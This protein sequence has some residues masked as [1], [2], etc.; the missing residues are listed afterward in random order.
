[1]RVF[2]RD[3]T[4][5]FRHIHVVM[6]VAILV[7]GLSLWFLPTDKPADETSEISSTLSQVGQTFFVFGFSAIAVHWAF[8]EFQWSVV[9]LSGESIEFR[10]FRYLVIH[11]GTIPLEDVDTI[12]F[13]G[14]PRLRRYNSP[15]LAKRDR[16]TKFFVRRK[17]GQVAMVIPGFLATA[18]QYLQVKDM[19]KEFRLNNGM[20]GTQREAEKTVLYGK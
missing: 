9:K 12:Y 13:I 15:S 19:V 4:L 20:S 1:M 17:D 2:Q 8:S 10:Y 18:K 6:P 11:Y 3:E 16:I 14:R 7:F 5:V